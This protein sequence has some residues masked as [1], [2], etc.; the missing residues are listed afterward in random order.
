[1]SQNQATGEPRKGYQTVQKSTSE[2]WLPAQQ[3]LQDILTAAQSQYETGVGT[4]LPDFS[5]VAGLGQGTMD[6]IAA[7]RNTAGQPRSLFNAATT[8][9]GDILGSG[10]GSYGDVYNRAMAP[11]AASTYLT[12]IAAGST[13]ND[14]PYFQSLLDQATDQVKSLYASSGRYGSEAHNR[15]TVEA[16][17]PLLYQNYEDELSRRMQAAGMLDE[18]NIAALGTG[19]GALKAGTDT[20]LDAANVAGIL[21]ESRYADIDRLLAAGAIED[22]NAAA[23]QLTDYERALWESGGADQAALQNYLS[24]IGSIG[25]MGRQ[26]NVQEPYRPFLNAL[27]VALGIADT[28][29][30]FFSPIKLPLGGG[31]PMGSDARLKV[32]IRRV[33]QTDD[34]LNIYTYKFV[35]SPITQMGV[36]AQEVQRSKPEA[37]STM[38]SG[39]LGVDYSMIS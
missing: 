18:A 29:G 38:A 10:M 19:L 14:N 20:Q 28:V 12:D 34:G 31:G 23:Q 4:A 2:P 36:M 30:G 24:L 35:G 16:L 6:A 5:P 27:Q 37:V 39:F 32:D 21:D 8:T 11:T 25:G 22:E 15:G 13:G 17:T 3:Q 9:V 33:G 1:M 26:E 7:L